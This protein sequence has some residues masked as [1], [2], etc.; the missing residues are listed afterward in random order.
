MNTAPRFISFQVSHYCE[1]VRWAMDRTGFAYRE[2]NH[3]PPLHRLKTM[4]LGGSTVPILVT[5]DAPLR[6]STDILKY[7]DAAAP[8]DRQ[9]Y[10]ESPPLRLEVEQLE[11]EF[12]RKLGVAMRQWAYFYVLPDRRLI[13]QLWSAGVPTWEK[14]LFS[15]TFP[16]TRRLVAQSYRVNREDSIAAYQ[17]TQ[18]IFQRVSDRL[19]DGRKYLVG[20]RLS[21]ADITFASLAA[22]GLRPAEYGGVAPML[23]QLPDAMVEQI[24]ALRETIAGQYALRLYREERHVR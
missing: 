4:P 12:S 10:P 13:Q 23:E 22:P 5:K 24:Q 18:R 16:L 3:L 20:D 14:R 11:A 21:A 8:A 19:S 15:L 7:L 6:D 17:R 9:L 2:E 1:K